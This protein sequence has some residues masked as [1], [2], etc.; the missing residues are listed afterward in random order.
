MSE[1]E[2]E[3]TEDSRHDL[4]DRLFMLSRSAQDPYEYEVLGRSAELIRWML[5]DEVKQA[6]ELER[7][8]RD[9][10]VLRRSVKEYRL[11]YKDLRD[12][13]EREFD[14]PQRDGAS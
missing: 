6:A 11:G 1:A 14:S 4:V 10:R 7:L 13:L 9:N 8:R 12:R 5:A 3:A 2:L